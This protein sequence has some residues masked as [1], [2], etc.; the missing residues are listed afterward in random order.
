M[1]EEK[2]VGAE[3]DWRGARGGATYGM[4]AS[5][6]TAGNSNVEGL[7]SLAGHSQVRRRTPGGQ[8]TSG[9]INQCIPGGRD[10]L[11]SSQRPSC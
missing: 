9:M 2:T 1:W 11:E 10:G 8:L 6:P 7:V 4:V 5:L 3:R